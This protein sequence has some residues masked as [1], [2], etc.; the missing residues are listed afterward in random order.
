M[1]SQAMKP[2]VGDV[3]ELLKVL[4]LT[5]FYTSIY[6]EGFCDV[7]DSSSR[8]RS[9]RRPSPTGRPPGSRDA[10]SS[11]RQWACARQTETKYSLRFV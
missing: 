10:A 6:I 5:A 1:K 11:P 7:A 8:A 3:V 9:R 4:N 2:Q